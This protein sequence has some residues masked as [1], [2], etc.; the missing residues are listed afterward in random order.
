MIPRKRQYR[1]SKLQKM[2]VIWMR[3]KNIPHHSIPN[4]GHR[5]ALQAHHLIKQGMWPGASDLFV[6]RPMGKFGG[7]YV[8]LKDKG[9]FPTA[10]QVHFMECMRKEGY[11]A[12]WFDNFDDAV[13]AIE[14]YL[15]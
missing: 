9:K 3:L 13:K 10:K 2:L 14:Q 15:N 6:C 7:F 4:E 1:E 8:E 11:R 5:S 12:E